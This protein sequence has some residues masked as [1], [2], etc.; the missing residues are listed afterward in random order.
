MAA[1]R[2][3]MADVA[4]A[5]GVSTALVS[6]VFREVPGASEAT[7][8]RV[9]RVADEL[10]YVPD[11]HAQKLRQIRS[12]LLGVT[13]E[14]QQP[15]HGDLVEQLYPAMADRGYDLVLSGIAPTR[16]EK[17]AIEALLRERCEALILLGSRLG[18]ADLGELAHRVPVQVVARAPGVDTV[19]AVRMDDDLGILLGVDHLAVL[20]HRRIA[21]I[22]GGDA[23][24]SDD[25][26][27]GFLRRT[28]ELGIDGRVVPGGAT[29][30]D[31]VSAMTALLDQGDT[32]TA[33]MAFN[34]RVA[35]GVLDVLLRRGKS[36]PQDIS[37]MGYDDSR[38]SRLAHIDLSTVAQDAN[39]LAQEVVAQ[40]VG[41]LGG[42]A[43]GDVVLPP[44][45]IARRT[46]GRAPES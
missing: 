6:I 44:T 27:S 15:F 31:G 36:V 34:D 35:I 41:Q 5:A 16:D 39:R 4:A 38:L 11:R 14:L 10:G 40:A 26:V 45:L 33:V 30:T 9:K 1:G 43:V 3:T 2:P 21:Y 8:E 32:A 23:P 17:T 25:R 46:T 18:P 12:E 19:G 20:G 37:V 7:R 22:D 29:E 24:G 13:F 42:H 28:R